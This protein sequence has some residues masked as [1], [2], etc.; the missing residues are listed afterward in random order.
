MA[1]EPLRH[2]IEVTCPECGQ[3]QIE[4]ALVV[5]TQCRAC[6]ANFQVR[7][8]KGVVRNR[9][10][11]RLAKPRRDSDPEPEIPPARKASPFVLR[12]PQP[13]ARSLLKRLFSP[14]K[15]P[16][17][18][19]CFGCGNHY[20]ASAEAQSSQC[21]KCS[22]YV[23]LQ[24]YEITEPWNRRI[25]TGGDVTITK[26]G[27]VSG[28]TLR[29]HNLLVL[30]ELAGSVECTGDLTIRSH[31]KIIG[32]VHCR[33]LRVE[34][35]ARVEFLHPVTAVTAYID[36]HVRGQISCTGSVTL[37]KRAH[38]QGLVRTSSLIV[39]PGAKHTGS[40]EMVTSNI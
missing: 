16:R 22:G 27:A 13:P 15:P 19:T 11:T 29:C 6:R 18:V 12:S 3:S 38:L 9:P 14:T 2:R 8:G 34:K 26:T 33:N 5:S 7:E 23:S 24:D 10:I 20:T 25:Q 17:A 36:G 1:D 39:K 40:I 28:V 4:P 31:G 35:G 30:G 21:P 32:R 37:Q